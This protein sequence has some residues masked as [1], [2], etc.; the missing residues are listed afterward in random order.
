M[1]TINVIHANSDAS[2]DA[3]LF[4]NQSPMVQQYIQNQ[5]TNFSETLTDI[6]R[7]FVETSKDL[8]E[9]VNDSNALRLAKAAVRM[10]KGMFHPNAII[11]L[12]SIEDVRAAQPLMQ[13][14]IMA[15][16][17]LRQ[18]Y[19][20]QLVDG[21]SDT[22]TDIDPGVFGENHYDYRRVMSGFVEDIKEEDGSD[23]WVSKNYYDELRGDDRELDFT[24]QHA[25]LLTWGVV[26][27]ALNAQRDPSDPFSLT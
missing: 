18:Q 22:Y 8:Y 3:L 4:Q 25:I 12:E 17:S 9:K 10:A 21:Y 13:R 5:L 11:P 15:E 24:E 23:G 1:S 14:Y 7:R 6:G 16:P 26:R 2:F 19:H 27:L 20:K